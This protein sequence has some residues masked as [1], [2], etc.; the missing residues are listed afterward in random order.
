MRHQVSDRGGKK[1]FLNGNLDL[2][3]ERLKIH[4]KITVAVTGD[5]KQLNS[6]I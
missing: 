2:K 4:V 3:M 6:I 5:F 1:F